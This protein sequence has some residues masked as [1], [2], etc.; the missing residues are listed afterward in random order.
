MLFQNAGGSVNLSSDL[1]G[2]LLENITVQEAALHA[3]IAI[4]ERARADAPVLSGTYKAS[5]G[6]ERFRGGARV[7]SDDPVAH[8]LEFGAPHRTRGGTLPARYIFRNAAASLGYTFRTRG[9][10]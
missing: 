8:L 6:V 2:L 3:A 7:V 9:G 4:A 1:E 10:A 5:I